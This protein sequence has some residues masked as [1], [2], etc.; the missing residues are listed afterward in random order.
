MEDTRTVIVIGG[1]G[2]LGRYVVRELAKQGHVVRVFSRHP[3][4][5]KYLKTA[6]D[7]GQ[8]V[9]EA[10]DLKKPETI[11]RHFHSGVYAVI[12]LVGL[13]YERGKQNFSQLHAVAPEKL[14]KAARAA[15]ISRFV[16]VSSLG[17]DKAVN[18]K[19]AR[20]KMTGEKAVLAAFPEATILRPSVIFGPEDN[21]IN[22]FAHMASISPFLPLIGGGKTRFQ[23]VYVAD[24]AKAIAQCL[25]TRETCG[26]I[27][28]LGGPRTYSFREI[29]DYIKSE[30]GHKS[31]YLGLSFGLAGL[32]GAFAEWLPTPPLTRDQVRMLKNDNVVSPE[33]KGLSQLGVTATALELVA[34]QYLVRYRKQPY[35]MMTEAS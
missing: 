35:T 31:H 2:F 33:S 29:L 1:T 25:R 28:E 8:I 27:Y 17:V 12:N 16:Q 21:F 22:K 26:Q 11:T 20:T 23:P 9:L 32:V 3:E 18:A 13:L 4:R 7:V 6:G 5:A 10:G 19:Y 15:G 34:P 14:A 24:V 30:T